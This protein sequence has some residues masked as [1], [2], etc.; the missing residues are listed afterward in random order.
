MNTCDLESGP[1]PIS[2]DLDFGDLVT[3]FITNILDEHGYVP[4]D[5]AHSIKVACDN[6]CCM[7]S[8]LR[9]PEF[10]EFC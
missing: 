7:L 10:E 2:D 1:L 5:G 3:D 4:S 6:V 9:H 8:K